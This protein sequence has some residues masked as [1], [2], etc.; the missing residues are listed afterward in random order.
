[1]ILVFL[2]QISIM[3]RVALFFVSLITVFFAAQSGNPLQSFVQSEAMKSA[4]VGILLVNSTKHDTILAFDQCKRLVPASL[5]KL[6][7][8]S[9]ALETLEPDFKFATKLYISSR[10]TMDGTLYGKL[11]IQAAADPTLA[12]KYFDITPDMVFEIIEQTLRQQNI[13]RI[14]GGIETNISIFDTQVIPPGWIWEDIGNYYAPGTYSM[15]WR[16]NMY[17]I[18]LKSGAPGS[19]VEITKTDPIVK[20]L[21]LQ[22]YVKAAGNNKDSAYVYGAPYSFNQ[23]IAGTIPA[24]KDGFAIKA[25]LPNPVL[26]FN[27]ELITYLNAKGIKV[28]NASTSVHGLPENSKLVKAIFSPPLYE[29]VQVTNKESVNLYA[30][31]ILKHLSLKYAQ[32]ANR[33]ESIKM[34]YDYWRKRKMDVSNIRIEDGSGLSPKNL[35]TADFMV[36]MLDYMRTKSSYAEYFLASLPVSGKDGT[37]KS[38]LKGTA[39]EG[40][41]YAKTG[42]M[43]GIRCYAGFAHA[44]SNDIYTFCILVNNYNGDASEIVAKTEDLLLEVI[45]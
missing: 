3:K 18:F 21:K 31:Y 34:V 41:V 23:Y 36:S 19:Q 39:L 7:T 1:M 22:S 2:P 35:V 15:A 45:K 24:F 9:T 32:T 5:L 4:S 44:P 16:D 17:S 29:I 12:S 37:L 11:I 30:E 38:F 26:Q 33:E 10:P 8:T 20:D 43:G 14:E 42:S 25:S 13:L 40:R 28:D 6:V 27:Q